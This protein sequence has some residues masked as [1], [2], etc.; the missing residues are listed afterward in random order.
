M[1]RMACPQGLQNSAQGFN[2]GNP[3]KKRFALKGREMPGISRINLA[4]IA[5]PKSESA[6]NWDVRQAA[7]RNP[8]IQLC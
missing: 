1:D 2:P 6:P 3:Q 5:A 8:P 4:P 7:H